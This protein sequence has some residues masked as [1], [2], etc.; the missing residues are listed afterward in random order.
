MK[1]KKLWISDFGKFKD[2]W[3]VFN[4]DSSPS[5]LQKD[6]Y[7]NMN[8][9]LLSGEN[10]S[11]KST[12][13]NFIALVF[14]HLQKGR[15][16]LND[17]KLFYDIIK[18]DEVFSIVIEKKD[19][20]I[21]F[22][23]NDNRFM[24]RKRD[25]KKENTSINKSEYINITEISIYIPSRI[26]VI[27]SD[28]CLNNLYNKPEF[29]VMRGQVLF[30][31]IT[32][33]FSERA[34]GIIDSLSIVSFYKMLNDSS[35]LE[36]FLKNKMNLVFDDKVFVNLNCLDNPNRHYREG[37]DNYH[38]RAYAHMIEVCREM[39]D[40]SHISEYIKFDDYFDDFLNTYFDIRAFMKQEEKETK[41]LKGIIRKHG[42]FINDLYL[43]KGGIKI[44]IKSFSTGEKAFLFSLFFLCEN[45][46]ENALIMWE[47]P[48]IHL[49]TI[50]IKELI[51][52]L[53]LLFKKYHTQWIL[54]SHNAYMI[55]NFFT[56]QVVRI[57]D[58]DISHPD[59]KTFLANESEIYNNLYNKSAI[60]GLE[61][62]VLSKIKKSGMDIRKEIFNELGESYIRFFAF[63]MM[64][65]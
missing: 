61:A 55:K 34:H 48:E 20:K 3:I 37:D 49:N 40:L 18:D 44:P 10:G 4:D 1:L 50:W 35:E 22:Q 11:G 29:C 17:Y 31:N 24:L 63:E 64:E 65:K 26:V 45:V 43:K 27:G 9:T 36:A 42:L 39:Y 46:E 47:E 16:K 12:M 57:T 56:K 21:S 62:I 51:P 59:F 32:S 19:T 23:V 58:D 5:K 28:G 33:N 6:I 38:F 53:T 52:L 7:G 13:V 60:S 14:K 2:Q 30:K 15:E 54:S 8:F 25:S 41:L